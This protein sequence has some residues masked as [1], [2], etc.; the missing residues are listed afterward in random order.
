[1]TSKRILLFVSLMTITSFQAFAQTEA[2][3]G[4]IRGRATD[5]SATAVPAATVTVNNVDT[6]YTRD[7]QTNDEGYFVIPNLPIG[8]YTVTIRKDGFE[9]ERHSGVVLNAGTEGVIDTQ[10]KVGAVS[11]TV[12]VTGGAPVIDPS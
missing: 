2:I 4:S 5:P 12:E 8:T 6:G 9:T 7:V 3:N 11:T 10:L 1:M